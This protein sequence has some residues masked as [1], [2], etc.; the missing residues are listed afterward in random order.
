MHWSIFWYINEF[1]QAIESHAWNIYFLASYCYHRCRRRRR[2]FH[3]NE[4][5]WIQLSTASLGVLNSDWYTH[6]V[7]IG[8]ILTLTQN[9]RSHDQLRHVE[10]SISALCS[11]NCNVIAAP[12]WCSTYYCVYFRQIV[13]KN[14]I[15]VYMRSLHCIMCVYLWI[16]SEQIE[17]RQCIECSSNIDIDSDCQKYCNI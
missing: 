14:I 6:I 4:L 15:N 9:F 10:K 5:N 1:D 2:P 13:R 3:F 7:K 8:F 16:E 17:L 12:Y 11:I